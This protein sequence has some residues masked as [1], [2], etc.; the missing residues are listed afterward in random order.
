[1]DEILKLLLLFGVGSIAGFINVMAGGGSTITLPTLIFLGLDGALANG[2]NR[3]GIFVQTLTAV[4]SFRQE[5]YHKIKL[6]LKLAAF[7][8]PG[9]IIG[10]IIAVNISNELFQKIL[11]YVLIGIIFSMLLRKI[12]KNK[13]EEDK[14][15]QNSWLIYPAMFVMG[16]YGGF[17][18]VGIGFMFMASLYHLL[19][20]KLLHVN[21]HKVLIICIYTLPAL[22]IFILTGNVNWKLGLVLAA[23]MASGAWWSAK[24]SIKKG[25][26]IIRII[27]IAAIL[28]MS[29][30]LLDVI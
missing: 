13:T 25:E 1:M 20:L 28:L 2:T 3:V 9:A 7:T 4:I 22:L 27:L 21:M 26:K 12:N 15:N 10:A 29:L 30:K 24:L 23:G 6:S 18:Q 16:F 8:L 5:K 14:Q 19:K 11:G 17:M